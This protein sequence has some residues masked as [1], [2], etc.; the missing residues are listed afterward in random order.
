MHCI[1]ANNKIALEFELCCDDWMDTVIVKGTVIRIIEATARV[2]AVKIRWQSK[3]SPDPF[4]VADSN[5][6]AIAKGGT[7]HEIK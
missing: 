3:F 2:D 4:P 6:T 1:E 5:P 7:Y